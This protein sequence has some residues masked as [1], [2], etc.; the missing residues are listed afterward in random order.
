MTI[1]NRKKNQRYCTIPAT[2][3][4]VFLY[5]LIWVVPN[6]RLYSGFVVVVSVC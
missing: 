2:P 1:V 6:K 3:G 4:T 5:C